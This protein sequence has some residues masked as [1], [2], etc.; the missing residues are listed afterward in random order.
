MLWCP[1]Q[2]GRQAVVEEVRSR[3]SLWKALINPDL[4]GALTRGGAEE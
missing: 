3:A 4:R 1:H 2:I